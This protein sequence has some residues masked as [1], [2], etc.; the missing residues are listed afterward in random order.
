MSGKIN[1]V[2]PQ[3][4][5]PLTP[6]EIENLKRRG[7]NQSQI[8]DLH[9][10]TRQAVSWQKV[11]YGGSLTTRQIVNRTWPFKT[12][13]L[14]GKS[15]AFQRLRDHGEYM[16][17]GSFKGMSEEKVRNLKRWWKRLLDEDIVV[18][19]DPSIEP[20]AGMA[21]GGFRYVPRRPE[22]DDLLIRV[23]KHTN[24]SEEGEMIWCWP[25][26]IDS[27]LDE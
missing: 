27:L 7:F 19:F 18:E 6:S 2:K 12:T 1:I 10:V 16:R 26:D 17:T 5:L 11:T 13:N 14:H 4:R 3:S 25:P 24:L 20:Y 15:K 21:G 9:G 22:D 8:A 23:N